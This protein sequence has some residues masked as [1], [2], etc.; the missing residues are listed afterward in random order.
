MGQ[1]ELSRSVA[2]LSRM[3]L[4]G[5]TLDS[6]LDRIARLAAELLPQAD[7]ASITISEAG[8]LARTASSTEEPEAPLKAP[9]RITVAE[10]DAG[11]NRLDEGPCLTAMRDRQTVQIDS[12]HTET[13]WQGFCRL[14]LAAGIE[15]VLAVPLGDESVEAPRG[16]RGHRRARPSRVR[17]TM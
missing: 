15:S 11:Q 10:L 7:A 3:L 17:T 4:K 16:A 12:M 6:T 13:R 8:G 9:G 2:A 5:E 14:A 1:D